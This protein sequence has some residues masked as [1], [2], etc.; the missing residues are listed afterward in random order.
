MYFSPHMDLHNSMAT[1]LTDHSK[2]LELFLRP[3]PIFWIIKGTFSLY[4][5]ILC[6]FYIVI[7]DRLCLAFFL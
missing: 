2:L 3:R 5:L 7:H 1:C 4:V 6:N